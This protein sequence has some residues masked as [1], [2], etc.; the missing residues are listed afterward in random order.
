MSTEILG[1]HQDVQLVIIDRTLCRAIGHWGVK[2]G[3]IVYDPVADRDQKNVHW[4]I[5]QNG[6]DVNYENSSR[7]HKINWQ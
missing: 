6:F 7:K 3:F 4:M 1:S 5:S 2:S